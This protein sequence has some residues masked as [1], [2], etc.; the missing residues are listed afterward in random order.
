MKKEMVSRRDALKIGALGAAGLAML[1]ATNA[2]AATILEKDVKFDETYDVIVIGTGF[3]GLAAAAKASQ[4]GLKVLVVEKMGRVGGNSVINGGGM[5]VPKNRLQTEYGIKDSNELF[6]KDCLKAGLG[7]NHVELLETIAN[8]AHEAFEFAVECGAKFQDDKPPLQFGGHTVP[9]SVFTKNS[10]GSG[11]IKP[12][13]KFVEG[14]PGCKIVRRTK[15][16]D[17]VM[18]DKGG[19]VG[20]TVRTGYRFNKK[21]LSD[22]AENTTGEKKV[23]R[24]KKGVILAAGGFSADKVFRKLQDPRL[25]VDQDVTNHLGATSGAM[26]KAFQIGAMPIHIGWIQQG[27][28]ASPDERGFGTAPHMTQGGVFKYGIA[29]DIR[30]GKRFMNEMADRKTR[31]D[32]EYRIL[33]EDPTANPVAFGTSNTFD[34]NVIATREKALKADVMKQFDTVDALAAHYKIPV[35]ALKASIKKY[36]DGT[37]KGVDEFGKPVKTYKG[38]CIEDKGP[39]F[40]IR[41]QP[42]P[43]HTMGGVKINT[44]AQVISGNTMKPIAGLYAAGEVTGGTHGAS[45]LGSVAVTDCLTFGM[46]AGENI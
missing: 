14:L 39:Y 38:Q 9:R 28:W 32:A 21:L 33:H 30:N 5:A 26:L 12:M 13:T 37:K 34:K 11:I 35:D 4:R 19:V 40:A 20:I 3:A 45:R 36:N 31:A 22:D 46:I 1:G 24:A 6:I 17:F 16:D 44:K 2:T 10:S 29:V 42:K 18:D 43:H 15:F 23:F 8:R 7:I 41:L 27:P 25:G